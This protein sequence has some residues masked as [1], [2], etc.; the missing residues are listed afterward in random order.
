MRRLVGVLRDGGG[1]G[2]AGETGGAPLGPQPGAADVPDLVRRC[3]AAG[4]DVRYEVTGAERELPSGVG[5]VVYRIVQEALANVMQH[6]GPARVEVGLRFGDEGVEL[7]VLDDGRGAGSDEPGTGGGAGPADPG[8]PDGPGGRPA[9]A[10]HGIAG[11]RERVAVYGGELA[12]GPRPGGG[13]RVRAT[14][15]IEAWS[16]ASPAAPA[17][18]P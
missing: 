4:L 5:L 8:S 18:V 3:R 1:D 2:R 12:A 10:G 15:P 11:M 13:F 14:L 17:P 7:T 16:A 6:A 9:R